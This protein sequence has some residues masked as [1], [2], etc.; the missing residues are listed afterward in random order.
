MKSQGQASD[1]NS[2]DGG[3]TEIKKMETYKALNVGKFDSKIQVMEK[4]PFDF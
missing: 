2:L 4:K 1:E 3:R